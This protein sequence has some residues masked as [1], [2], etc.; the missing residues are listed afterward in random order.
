[1]KQSIQAVLFDCDGTLIKSLFIHRK[2]YVKLAKELNLGFSSFSG[3][4]AC[5]VLR[6]AGFSQNK[7]RNYLRRFG[8]LELNSKI[9]LFPGIN[10]LLEYLKE[11]KILRGI[12]T[13]RST[14]PEYFQLLRNIS[15]NTKL[16]NF[17]LNC[18]I[19]PHRTK[20][21]KN[22]FFSSFCKPDRRMIFP[23]LNKLTLLEGFPGSVVMVG[24]HW[25][26]FEFARRCGFQFVA[27]LSGNTKS[28][29]EWFA[30][31]HQGLI[32][33]ETGKLLDIL[34]KHPD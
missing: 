27:V 17:Y 15:L 19:F 13:N 25:V 1:M 10:E 30:V 5:S 33:K 29:S 28:R 32:L 23:L 21:P 18:D 11:K 16:I 24:D 26:D 6:N 31:G 3:K 4:P 20:A 8:K 12:V 22:H 2:L 9:S 7:I 34:K 14:N